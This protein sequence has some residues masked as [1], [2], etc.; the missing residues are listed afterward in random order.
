MNS[1]EILWDSTMRKLT[2]LES[3]QKFVPELLGFSHKLAFLDQYPLPLNA[4]SPSDTC[5]KSSTEANFFHLL[6]RGF[7]RS[8]WPHRPRLKESPLKEELPPSTYL[9]TKSNSQ[10]PSQLNRAEP[11]SLEVQP[12][13]IFVGNGLHLHARQPG[14]NEVLLCVDRRGPDPGLDPE[15]HRSRTVS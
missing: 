12:R 2:V 6:S 15:G 13:R 5:S 3:L 7:R 14:E 8:G 11:F 9:S 10:N 1:L 4:A